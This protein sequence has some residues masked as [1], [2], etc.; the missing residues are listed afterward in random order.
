LVGAAAGEALR[1]LMPSE[2]EGTKEE[3]MPMLVLM[4]VGAAAVVVSNKRNENRLTWK[5]YACDRGGA[6]Q[7]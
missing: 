2:D 1:F 4:K 7:R 6:V 3:R 5:H